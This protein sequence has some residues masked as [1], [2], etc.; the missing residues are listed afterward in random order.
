MYSLVICSCN[1]D[2]EMRASTPDTVIIISSDDEKEDEAKE[3]VNAYFQAVSAGPPSV[4][5]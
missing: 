2:L 1:T 5:S 4:T 3:V